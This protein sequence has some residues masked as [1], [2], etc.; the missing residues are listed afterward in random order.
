MHPTHIFLGVYYIGQQCQGESPNHTSTVKIQ[1]K[2]PTVPA[3]FPAPSINLTMRPLSRGLKQNIHENITYQIFNGVW[4]EEYGCQIHLDPY[5]SIV[6]DFVNKNTQKCDVATVDNVL[7]ESTAASKNA[8]RSIL[9]TIMS[10]KTSENYDQL[11]AKLV[12]HQENIKIAKKEGKMTNT[13]D[14]MENVNK[15]QM[16]EF[17]LNDN[18]SKVGNRFKRHENSIKVATA[19]AIFAENTRNQAEYLK[20]KKLNKLLNWNENV[21]DEQLEPKSCNDKFIDLMNV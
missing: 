17:L 19:L 21:V 13:E 6:L 1:S 10:I 15:V 16:L 5:D 12:H 8:N 14:H 20:Q 9:K 2:I 11:L 7:L 3:S 18:S 4:S